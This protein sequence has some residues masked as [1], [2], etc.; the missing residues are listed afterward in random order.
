VTDPAVLH[1]HTPIACATTFVCVAVT[2]SDAAEVSAVVSSEYHSD[3]DM[4][5]L[6]TPLVMVYSYALV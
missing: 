1:S 5:S 6:T 3:M 2:V 4:P